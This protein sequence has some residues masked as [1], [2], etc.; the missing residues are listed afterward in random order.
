MNL[1]LISDRG[2]IGCAFPSKLRFENSPNKKK[3]KQVWRFFFLNYLFVTAE[4]FKPPTLRAE[5]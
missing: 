5:I 3:L 1:D 2:G 4:G